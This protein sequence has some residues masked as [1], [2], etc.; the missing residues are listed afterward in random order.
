[1]Q[2]S[3][4]LQYSLCECWKGLSNVTVKGLKR[5]CKQ[6]VCGDIAKTIKKINVHNSVRIKTLLI[7]LSNLNHSETD[8]EAKSG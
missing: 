2:K 4:R 8:T 1:M 5:F 3:I 6:I 7:I